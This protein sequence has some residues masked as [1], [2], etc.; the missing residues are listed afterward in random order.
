M[1]NIRA[2]SPYH[3][4]FRRPPSTSSVPGRP[5]PLF[6]YSKLLPHPTVSTILYCVHP[7]RIGSY[8]ARRTRCSQRPSDAVY[9][10]CLRKNITGFWNRPS[11]QIRL[12]ELSVNLHNILIE[13]PVPML[14]TK[15]SL[16]VFSISSLSLTV[17]HN[18]THVVGNVRHMHKDE[19][20]VK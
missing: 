9:L 18:T 7:K 15:C 3:P 10:N 8:T 17:I 14:T 11:L 2:F 6:H 19:I 16:S 12:S 1:T 4:S 13:S 5:S 20:D